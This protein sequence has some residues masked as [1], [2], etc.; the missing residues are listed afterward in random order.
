MREDVSKMGRE[1]WGGWRKGLTGFGAG[2]GNGGGGRREA[3][4]SVQRADAN[5]GHPAYE[6]ARSR[7]AFLPL[8]LQDSFRV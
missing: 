7:G 2:E 8:L 4:V 5:L 6:L 1:F 3:Q